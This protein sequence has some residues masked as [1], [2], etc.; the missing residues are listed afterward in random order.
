MSI[1]SKI[2]I[3]LIAI[4]LIPTVILGLVTFNKYRNSL[5]ASHIT[6]LKNI[7]HLQADKIDLYFAGLKT[8][9]ELAQAT[10]VIKNNLPIL[11][12]YS[13]QPDSPE[14]IN[15]KQEMDG[16]IKQMQA[17]FK[18]INVLI[19]SPQGK[20]VYLSNAVDYKNSFLKPITGGEQKAFE[21]GKNGIYFSDMYF[22][23]DEGDKNVM[24]V[25]GPVFDY[26]R[27]FIGVI[28]FKIDMALVYTLIEDTAG[29]GQTG[30]VVIAKKIGKEAVYLNPLKYGN[31]SDFKKRIMLGEKIALPV[32][33]A[34]QGRE[35]AGRS[36]DYRGKDVI[37]AWRYVPYI[38]WGIVAKIDTHEAFADIFDLHKLMMAIIFVLIGL[39]C[40]TAFSIAKSI[41]MPIKRLAQGAEIVGAGNLD[42][43]F[44]NNSRDEIGY[45]STAFDK[46][47]KDLKAVTSSRDELNREI[48]ERKQAE[49]ALAKEKANLQAIFDVVNIGMLL[50]DDKGVVRRVNNT[51]SKWV[52]KDSS[53]CCGIQP[54]DVVCCIHALSEQ[55][56][57]GNTVYCAECPIRKAFESVLKTGVPMNAETE[58]TLVIEG[59][60]A[61][62]W[63]DVNA[64]FIMIDDKPHV[65][66]SLNNITVR[67]QAEDALRRV[68]DELEVRVQA[69][70]VELANE[71]QRL[72]SV[73]E[74]LPVYVVLLTPDY[75]IS[76]ANKFFRERFGEDHGRTCFNYLFDK[77]E[78]CDSCETYKVLKTYSPHHWEWT[79]PDGRNYDIYD[80]PFKETD[81]SIHIMEMGIDITERKRVESELLNAQR[82]LNEAKRLSD[83]G[84]LAA[85]VAHELRNPLAA[86]K[87]AGYNI[88]KKA[89]NP[90]L[91]KHLSNIDTKLAESEQIISNLL[92][93]SRI[94][95][96][97]HGKI[98][99]YNILN[100]CI[101]EASSQFSK[102]SIPVETRMAPIKNMLIEADPVQI[103]EVFL[104]ILNNAFDAFLEREGVI[105]VEAK[106]NEDNEAIE[107]SIRDNG[108]G[109]VKEDLDKV[110]EPFFTNKAK[111][112]GL[113]LSVCRQIMHL[114]G[115]SVSIESEKDK[116]TTVTL[117]LPV[118]QKKNA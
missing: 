69:R 37:A 51:L 93:Y 58:I 113:G 61:H 4:A 12:E 114:H 75:H 90:S 117:T 49:E 91:D 36:V 102:Y 18:L 68:R 47:I 103:K 13:S 77:K 26:K 81:G 101:T 21:E 6:H 1:R 82:E 54:G 71:R 109:I 88:K 14:F 53:S 22:N 80:F 56:G 44:R 67:K 63:L 25:T 98:N 116:G 108:V 78:P 3:I 38:G 96:P 111:G 40:I 42:Y 64:N 2:T 8:S 110:F 97:H 48:A 62:L 39:S 41:S 66:L 30:E 118:K 28:L 27:N 95:M 52:N 55:G 24:L 11:S 57:C 60:K 46:M 50:V 15:S 19:L 86:I 99:I 115:G 100:A 72:Y 89:Q 29:L 84:F 73:M 79:G 5:E 94:K 20:V 33:E 59:K 31:Q 43:Q 34:V 76:F 92:F 74:T 32:Q 105:E 35:G 45:L 83:I 70:T 85:T 106:T 16:P 23:K 87:M 10:Y 7:A 107:I 17:A 112:T 65:I 104:N 9:M